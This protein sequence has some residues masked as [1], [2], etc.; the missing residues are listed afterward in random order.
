[1]GES[2]NALDDAVTRKEDGSW[3]SVLLRCGC[4]ST[5]LLEDT[6]AVALSR[7]SITRQRGGRGGAPLRSIGNPATSLTSRSNTSL[8]LSTLKPIQP[9]GPASLHRLL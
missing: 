4:R 6:Q 8:S 2:I 5:G 9:R 7:L 1:M 3:Q